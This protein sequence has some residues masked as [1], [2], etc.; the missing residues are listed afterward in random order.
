M[1]K[2]KILNEKTLNSIK[3]GTD[4]KSAVRPVKNAAKCL[5]SLFKNC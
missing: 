1:T 5:F 3:G 4:Y 2:I